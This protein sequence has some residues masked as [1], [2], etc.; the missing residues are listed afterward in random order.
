MPG[1]E[2]VSTLHQ[3]KN[4]ILSFFKFLQKK[5]SRHDKIIFLHL[6]NESTGFATYPQNYT[7]K[8]RSFFVKPRN[9][10]LQK[11][12]KCQNVIFGPM[13]CWDSLMFRPLGLLLIKS[14]GFEGGLFINF[15]RAPFLFSCPL[16]GSICIWDICP[17]NKFDE[18]A[19]CVTEPESH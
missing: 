4:D 16:R 13:Y 1:H 10:F 18:K 5:V 7:K 19:Q 11:F 17:W 8:C 3:P 9:F 15:S 14:S 12:E 2:A 6:L